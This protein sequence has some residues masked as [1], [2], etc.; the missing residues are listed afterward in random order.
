MEYK[1]PQIKIAIKGTHEAHNI[2]NPKGIAPTCRE[3]YR[4]VTKIIMNGNVSDTR[5]STNMQSKS[6][7][8]TSQTTKMCELA[9]KSAK[10]V[11][12]IKI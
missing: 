11:K 9:L 1:K 3:M 12:E 8:G 10:T 4:K 2:Y 7:E 6:T 5:K